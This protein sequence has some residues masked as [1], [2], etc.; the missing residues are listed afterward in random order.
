MRP[1]PHPEFID[2]LCPKFN[3]ANKHLVIIHFYSP[4]YNLIKIL[5]NNLMNFPD[6]RGYVND[7][8]VINSVNKPGH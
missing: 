8:F 4:Y 3:Q 1:T 2:A 6:S 7:Q 5:T